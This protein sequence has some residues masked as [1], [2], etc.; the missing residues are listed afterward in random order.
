MLIAGLRTAL[1]TACRNPT[2]YRTS[3]KSGRDQ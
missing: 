2:P 3:A 1:A